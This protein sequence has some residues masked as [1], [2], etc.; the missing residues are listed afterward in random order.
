MPLCLDLTGNFVIILLYFMPKSYVSFMHWISVFVEE[1][2]YIGVAFPIY[3]KIILEM[4]K[5]VLL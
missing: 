3:I 4:I 2:E 5:G 1:K